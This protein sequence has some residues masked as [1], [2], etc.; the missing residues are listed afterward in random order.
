MGGYSKYI[1]IF[2]LTDLDVLIYL[3]I[4]SGR[5]MKHQQSEHRIAFKGEL[6]TT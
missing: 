5:F 1:R 3:N 4:K 6:G 2:E